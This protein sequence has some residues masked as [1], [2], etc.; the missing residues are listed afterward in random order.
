MTQSPFHPIILL[1]RLGFVVGAMSV[2]VVPSRQSG[3]LRST[4]VPLLTVDGERYVVAERDGLDW[5]LNARAA[6]RGMLRRGRVDEDVSLIE[7]PIAERGLI[8]REMPRQA[9]GSIAPF[10]RLH[11]VA[12]DPEAFAG[13]AASCPVFRVERRQDG[14]TARRLD[15]ESFVDSRKPIAD[16]Q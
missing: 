7:L 13:L 10:Q 14:K 15:G 3:I 8:L 9:P 5:V 16:I 2:L 4:L 1:Q 11:G 6:G 12:A